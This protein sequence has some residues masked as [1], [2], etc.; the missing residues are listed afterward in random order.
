MADN[1]T[2][3]FNVKSIIDIRYYD[4]IQGG[5]TGREMTSDPA[6]YDPVDGLSG[7]Y[8]TNPLNR[9]IFVKAQ[10]DDDL[11]P[12][13]YIVN[14][15]HTYTLFL[16]T[17]TNDVTV[18][19]STI[20]SWIVEAYKTE[21][22]RGA[23]ITAYR[24]PGEGEELN[25][26]KQLITNTSASFYDEIPV[27]GI[28]PFNARG[29]LHDGQFGEQDILVR[30]LNH[31]DISD[32]DEAIADITGGGSGESEYPLRASFSHIDVSIRSN[33]KGFTY[34]DNLKVLHNDQYID[35]E[36]LIN[37]VVDI[38]E[39]VVTPEFSY[40]TVS[41]DSSL[42]G[43]TY[44]DDLYIK[45][46]GNTYTSIFEL[47]NSGSGTTTDAVLTRDLSVNVSS[48]SIG[49]IPN[50][51]LFEAG[52][53]LEQIIRDLL[54]ERFCTEAYTEPSF[55]IA[56][57]S[58]IH[59]GDTLVNNKS[60]IRQIPYDVSYTINAEYTANYGPMKDVSLYTKSGSTYSIV[61]GTWTNNETQRKKT[62]VVNA[63]F[64]N[65]GE[66]KISAPTYYCGYPD[67]TYD[68]SAK[69][70]IDSKG[71]YNG[72]PENETSTV[73]ITWKDNASG[74]GYG[75]VAASS[76][77]TANML[78]DRLGNTIISCKG[79]N[80]SSTYLSATPSSIT[81]VRPLFYQAMTTVDNGANAADTVFDGRSS[82]IDNSV[83]NGWT[84]I[85]A[86]KT[87]S[88]IVLPEGTRWFYIVA[89]Y[90]NGIANATITSQ[91]FTSA[92]SG[93]SKLERTIPVHYINNLSTSISGYATYKFEWPVTDLVGPDTTITVIL[94]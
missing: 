38:P 49:G 43:H 69:L 7:R 19:P 28:I 60:E 34:I 47:I 6:V 50:N 1:Y 16:K 9:L 65:T 66:I 75:K 3:F 20:N 77:V 74:K 45:E 94:N 35:L 10:E 70:I 14:P 51:T 72:Y 48:D 39:Y 57:V 73:S 12:Y 26:L 76:P 91:G 62:K 59:D 63:S 42:K 23:T 58:Y 29:F 33:L 18:M 93:Y 15:G 68:A 25:E 92:F 55:R 56:S 17:F 54:M 83:I 79:K 27:M 22:S 40:L 41:G 52:T 81:L 78:T 53:T 80:T 71:C 30:R 87:L 86:T 44:I 5:H 24:L 21:D 8:Q 64:R 2:G 90:S 82:T 84:R 46:R 85:I 88:N 11:L 4:Y 37:D 31:K 32:W 61:D 13:D 89:P 67:G 36:T